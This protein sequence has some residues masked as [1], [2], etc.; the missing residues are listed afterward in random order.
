[1]L[2]LSACVPGGP[3]PGSTLRVST[4]MAVGSFNSQTIFGVGVANQGIL[5]ATEGGFFE[6]S[7][8]YQIEANDTFGEVTVL[9]TDPLTVHYE[10][11]SG[12]TWSDGVP[13][14]AA[15]LLLAWAGLSGT[16]N[17]PDLIRGDLIDP[18]SGE[19]TS[20]FTDSTV[21]FD[22][23]PNGLNRVTEIPKIDDSGRGIT[24]VYASPAVDWR[25]LFDVGVAAHVVG[26]RALDI[27][28]DGEAAVAVSEAIQDNDRDALAAISRVWSTGFITSTITAPAAQLLSVGPYA[29]TGTEGGVTLGA[30]RAYRGSHAA[31]VET[32]RVTA[33]TDAAAAVAAI[34]AGDLDVATLAPTED[35]LTALDAH[36][37]EGAADGDTHPVELAVGSGQRF[38]HLDLQFDRSA[39]GTFDRAAVRTAF[40]LTV[41]REAIID[42]IVRPFDPDAEPRNSF[43]VSPA[44]PGYAAVAGLLSVGDAVDLPR[45]RQLLAQENVTDPTVC[46]LFDS[47]NARRLV[48][49]ELIKKSAERAGFVVTDCSRP[50]WDEYLGVPEAYDAALF[51]WDSTTALSAVR[52]RFASRNAIANFS[53]FSSPPVDGAINGLFGDRIDRDTELGDR[54][55]SAADLGPESAAAAEFTAE[56]ERQLWDAG[57]GLP[58]FQHPE[59]ALHRGGIEGISLTPLAPGLLWNVSEWTVRE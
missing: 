58:L 4:P 15:D 38:E 19:A 47:E 24:L 2:V 10:V 44:E 42:A 17:D 27:A 18:D 41:P 45:A 11:A 54:G 53:Y 32:I 25:Y 29:V 20:G 23:I 43:L 59:V 7:A 1:M 21:F 35:V 13:V 55:V 26:E 5:S 6:H 28:D 14:G 46:V 31:S 49:F 33:G 57:Y 9:S 16:L 39:N 34:A 37:K 56:I 52:E 51:S 3:D 36:E 22:G 50:D 40:L 48:Q 8:D 30:N 12:T